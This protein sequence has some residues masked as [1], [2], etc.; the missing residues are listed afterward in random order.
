[1]PPFLAAERAA[2]PVLTP[3]FVHSRA[4]LVL[5]SLVVWGAAALAAALGTTDPSRRAAIEAIG[6]CAALVGLAAL[7]RPAPAPDR[8]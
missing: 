2:R 6:I 8:S 7:G 5:A 4:A 1:V 3:P